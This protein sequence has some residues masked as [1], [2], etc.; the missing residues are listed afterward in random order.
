MNSSIFPSRRR[1]ALAMLAMLTV[2]QNVHAQEASHNQ[3]ANPV[4]AQAIVPPAIYLS[5]LQ[6]YRP[7]RDQEV[8][9]W[10]E[11]NDSTA[12]IGGWRVYAKQA[13]EPDPI[14]TKPVVKEKK[15]PVT[16]KPKSID[17]NSHTK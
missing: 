6:N 13:R 17:H 3:R 7:F 11:L 4:N 5:T 16:D 2:G 9:F 15:T 14:D 1:L 10:R 8:G 12:R